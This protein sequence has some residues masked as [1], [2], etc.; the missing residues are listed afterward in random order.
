MKRNRSETFNC[1]L[2]AVSWDSQMVG[3]GWEGWAPLNT[4]R[5]P[6]MKWPF[7]LEGPVRGSEVH[8]VWQGAM[9]EEV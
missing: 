1:M 2:I 6:E 3:E 8:G 5:L 7:L 4:A 9:S